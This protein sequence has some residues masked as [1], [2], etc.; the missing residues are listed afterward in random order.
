[1]KT[2]TMKPMTLKPLLFT[3][4]MFIGTLYL[5]TISPVRA[6]AVHGAA[7]DG[8]A[9]TPVTSPATSA[10]PAK[11]GSILDADFET[12]A[13]YSFN[14]PDGPSTNAAALAK[15]ARQIPDAIKKL[16]GKAVR[17]R[18]FMMP[19]KELAGKTTEF[20]IMRGQPSCCFSGATG[21]NEFVTVKMTGQGV[22]ED[23]D[24]PVAIEGIL[25]VGVETDGGF[26]TGLYRMDGQKMIAPKH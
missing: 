6:Q 17:I 25:H 18:G 10:A 15:V 20:M 9:A 14:V 24:D 7:I 4:A 26:V 16:D 19:V 2:F 23:M 13:A 8:A 11:V 12:L 5:T 22:D 1:M 3:P 21:V